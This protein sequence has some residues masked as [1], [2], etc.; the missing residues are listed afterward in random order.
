MSKNIIKFIKDQYD[1]IDSFYYYWL[2]NNEKDREN[3]PL[4]FKDDVLW[5]EMFKTFKEKNN[6]QF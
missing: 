2:E 6:E 1:I 5:N 3:F 4:S